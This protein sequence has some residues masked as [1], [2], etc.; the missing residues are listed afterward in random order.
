M[1]FCEVNRMLFWMWLLSLFEEEQ[2]MF[3][4]EGLAKMTSNDSSKLTELSLKSD[5]AY[6]TVPC[7]G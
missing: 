5:V 6:H 1:V 2:I 3:V 7:A 4:H